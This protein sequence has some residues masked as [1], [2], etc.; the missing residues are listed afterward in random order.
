MSLKYEF[1]TG[2]Y[3][4]RENESILHMQLDAET[5][6]LT[7][8]CG[9]KGLCYPSYLAWNYEK[10]VLYAVEEQSPFGSIHALQCQ[11]GQLHV[12]SSHVTNGADPCYIGQNREGTY[13]FAANYTSGSLAVFQTDQTGALTKMSGFVKHEGSG[14]N[15]KR[16]ESAHVHYCSV[17]PQNAQE[18]GEMIYVADLG[19]DQALVYH[20][21]SESGILEDRGMRLNFPKGS[22]PRHLEFDLT[23]KDV[24]YGV[25][26]LSSEAVVL[27]K[28]GDTYQVVQRISTLPEK[29][30]GENTAAAI[31][32]NQG[33]LFISNRGHDSI[34]MFRAKPNG[35]LAKTAIVS[36]GGKTPR[37]FQILG[38]WL[39][40]ANQDSD[41]LTVMKIDWE[42][43]TL[44]RMGAPFTTVRPTCICKI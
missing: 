18:D 12:L 11:N 3:G 10:K 32:M 23:N 19:L 42:Y 26:E 8:V 15:L 20:L 43:G 9:Y 24:I 22:G 40:A 35:L 27:K 29:Y 7:K 4:T 1:L 34:A 30:D 2:S 44:K 17:R 5:G 36:V 38:D 33:Y 31:R 28:Y 25:C 14:P 16:Q 6:E 13:V 37:D 41:N 39:V 21:D